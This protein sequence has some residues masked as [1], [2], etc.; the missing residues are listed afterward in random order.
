[1]GFASR[2]WPIL[3]IVSLNPATRQVTPG[4]DTSGSSGLPVLSIR[5]CRAIGTPAWCCRNPI[6][7]P[8]FR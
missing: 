1:M 6:V 3:G 8:E 2:Q 5:F 7:L 4:S